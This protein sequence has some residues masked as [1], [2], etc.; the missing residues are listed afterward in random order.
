MDP[1]CSYSTGEPRASDDSTR[2][3]RVA[4]GKTADGGLLTG[5]EGE[6]MEVRA[7]RWEYRKGEGSA[8]TT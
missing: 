2:G 6:M 4:G 1:G 3:G 8:R 7:A 5:W